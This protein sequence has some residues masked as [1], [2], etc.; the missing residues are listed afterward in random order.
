MTFRERLTEM[1]A[2]IFSVTADSVSDETDFYEDLG[3]DSLDML[4]LSYMLEEEYGL[5]EK[6]LKKYKDV[7]LFGELAARL[8]EILK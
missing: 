3:A 5:T 2:D 1:T 7:T 4:E 6:Q 8:E